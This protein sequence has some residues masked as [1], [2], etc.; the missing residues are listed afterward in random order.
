MINCSRRATTDPA[1][2]GVHQDHLS[3]IFLELGP[4]VFQQN[5]RVPRAAGFAASTTLF[6]VVVIIMS[7]FGG[8]TLRYLARVIHHVRS[9]SRFTGYSHCES[10]PAFLEQ[11]QRPGGVVIL[12]RLDN[13]G[14]PCTEVRKR[15]SRVYGH[16][17]P[18]L[19]TQSSRM[20]DERLHQPLTTEGGRGN[21]FPVHF[22]RQA[23]GIRRGRR[24]SGSGLR[25][26]WT[27]RRLASEKWPRPDETAIG[28]AGLGWGALSTWWRDRPMK[29][30]F[31]A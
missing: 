19:C 4:C 20:P 5:R 24:A 22:W 30:F 27:N 7:S 23:A 31:W 18:E 14:T 15:L 26:C 6:Q 28:R 16:L 9:G 3:T 17:L 2:A 12:C 29:H 1:V 10:P 25:P 8:G 13:M 11:R 21:H